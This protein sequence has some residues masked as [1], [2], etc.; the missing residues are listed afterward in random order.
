MARNQLKELES[1]NKT[2]LLSSLEAAVFAKNGLIATTEIPKIYYASRTHSQLSQVMKELKNTAYKPSVSVL[3]SRDQLCVHEEV[4]NAPSFAKTGL[5]RVKVAKKTCSFFAGAK[6][7]KNIDTILDIEELA[8]YGKKINA[9]PYYL[10]KEM[11]ANADIIFLPYNYLI[12]ATS[13]RSQSIDVKNSI[14]IFD[15]GIIW[16][17]Y[18]IAHNLENVCTESTSFEM[19]TNDINS[20]SGELS[21]CMDIISQNPSSLV[22]VKDMSQLRGK[23]KLN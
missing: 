13:R 22:S 12:D 15:E 19:N 16:N 23:I 4:Y 9:C 5:C 14:I 10:S 6:T 17:N 11:Q 20:C 7:K 18:L 3:G 8:I 2:D 21:A 1:N